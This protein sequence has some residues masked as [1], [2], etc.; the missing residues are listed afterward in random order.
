MLYGVIILEPSMF[1]CVIYNYM[2]VIIIY[3][4]ILTSNPKSKNKKINRKENGNEKR[5]KNK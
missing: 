1:F 5:D 4:V 2:T 3:D